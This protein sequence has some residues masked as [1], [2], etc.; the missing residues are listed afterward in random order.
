MCHLLSQGIKPRIYLKKRNKTKNFGFIMNKVEKVLQ[1]WKRSLFSVAGKEILIKGVGL[2]IPS[3]VMSVFKI[4]KRI[5]EEIKRN[6][7][8]FW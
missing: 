7:A 5:C 6:F 3:Y 1:G 2:A 8:Q 4:P